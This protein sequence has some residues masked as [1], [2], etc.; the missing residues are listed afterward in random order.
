MKI[1]CYDK[2][3]N[4]LNTELEMEMSRGNEELFH[5]QSVPSALLGPCPVEVSS[6]NLV[7]CILPGG[8][9]GT[10]F[11]HAGSHSVVGN[12]LLVHIT[13]TTG[14]A[15]VAAQGLESFLLPTLPGCHL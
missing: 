10:W 2:N 7:S 11:W 15:P 1:F 14:T 8:S 6:L 5:P 9:S 4:I 3:V 12:N 13:T